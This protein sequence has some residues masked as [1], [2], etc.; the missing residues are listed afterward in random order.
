LLGE[1]KSSG[2]Y[3][4]LE[5]ETNSENELDDTSA[6]VSTTSTT[7]AYH[8]AQHISGN[9]KD[10]ELFQANKVTLDVTRACLGLLYLLQGEAQ[11]HQ[12]F[13]R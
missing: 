12:E 2:I 6:T 8:T 3:K 9:Y 1:K 10:G 11:Y 4:S 7:H 5:R 13:Y